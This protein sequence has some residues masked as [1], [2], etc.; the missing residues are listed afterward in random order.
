[1][2]ALT[3]PS[4]APVQ[5]QPGHLTPVAPPEKPPQSPLRKGLVLLIVLAAAGVVYQLWVKPQPAA[6]NVPV[7]VARTAKVITGPFERTIRVS[8]VTSA[9]QFSDVTAPRM[10]GFESGSHMEL[11]YVVNNGASVKNGQRLAQI[12]ATAVE[13]HVDDIK[14][15][16]VQAEADVVKRRAEQSVEWDTLQQTLRVAKSN[17][18]KARWD[19]Q[20]AEVRTDI[21]R[22]LLKLSHEEAEAQYKQAQLEIPERKLIQDAE[23]KILGV[24]RERHVRHRMRHENDI[25][26]YTVTAHM[27]GMVVLATVFRGGGEGQQVQQG[28]Q[29][30]SGQ[31]LLKIVNPKSMQVEGNVNQS[32][33][34]DFRIGQKA[35]IGLDAFP[36]VRLEGKVFSIGALAVGG[37]RQNYYIRNVPIRIAIDGVDE[38][39]IPDLSTYADVVVDSK[40]RAT[41]VPLGAV[42]AEKNKQF[43]FVKQ[44]GG[45]FEKREVSLG[46]MNNL[47]AVCLSGLSEGEEVKLD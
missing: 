18:D 23:L 20:A 33:A 3:N 45:T 9:R 1:M 16:I 35:L 43:V 26:A 25:K 6:Q 19:N 5:K 15:T 28:D 34:T 22:E 29:L 10:R 42:H 46:D 27:D 4:P 24:T 39:L 36:G 14:A 2:S 44:P 38:R 8:G 41:M 30:H 32:E 7:V 17:V 21:E 47:Y 13:D 37:W 40:D 11:L 31:P 12:D